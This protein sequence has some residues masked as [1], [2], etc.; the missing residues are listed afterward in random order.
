MDFVNTVYLQK[1]STV[2]TL[3]HN[4]DIL[5]WMEEAGI[6]THARRNELNRIWIHS[7]ESEAVLRKVH[8]FRRVC[9]EVLSCI[10]A[11]K[12]VPKTATDEINFI[13]SSGGM[14]LR[15][16]E[17]PSGFKKQAAY[18]FQSPEH[19]VVPLAVSLVDLLESGDPSRIKQC[20]NP[21]CRLFFYDQG[22]NKTRRW[23]SMKTCGNRRKS[24]NVYAR[25]RA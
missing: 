16:E 25:K 19:F 23:C 13:L 11:H 2:E 12:P 20:A 24:A 5:V 18:A 10:M 22:K 6:L 1:N 9:F 21:R 14:V 3:Q 7:P 15:L 4:K 17:S 8:K